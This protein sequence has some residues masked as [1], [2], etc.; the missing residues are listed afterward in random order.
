MNGIP[1]SKFAHLF[2]T[3][4]KTAS[5]SRSVVEYL[6]SGSL[7]FWLQKSFGLQWSP[8][9]CS[10]TA[11]IPKLDASVITLVSQCD[12]QRAR[13]SAEVT[14]CCNAASA[15]VD[16]SVH[17]NF[18]LLL[19]SEN[20]GA[21]IV[22]RCGI[23]SL[24]FSTNPKNCRTSLLFL[25]GACHACTIT[26]FAFEAEIPCALNLWLRKF[27]CYYANLHLLILI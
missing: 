2:V 26:F 4:S 16:A 22:A 12:S 18:F 6:V 7:N 19:V 13:H 25:S 14:N 8:Y 9:F 23:N 21:A 24:Y 10:I 27:T 20:N 11:P 17:S 1:L 3:A 5:H 15:C